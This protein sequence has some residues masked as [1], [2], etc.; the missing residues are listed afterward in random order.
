MGCKGPVTYQ[1]CPN[2]GWNERHQLADRLRPP[3][4][5]LRR[6]R[7]LGH[8]D[9]RS[10]RTWPAF[11]GFG[12]ALHVDKVGLWATAGV[13]A[14]FAAHGFVQLGKRYAHAKARRTR[15]RRSR[16]PR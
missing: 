6:A 14:A 8:D 5:R 16:R 1:N 7:L 3:L 12:V 9:A 10:T 13:A 15:H 11:P 2:V 4:H